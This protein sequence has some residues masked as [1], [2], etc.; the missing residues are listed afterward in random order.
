MHRKRG[1]GRQLL[2]GMLYVGSQLGCSNAWGLT[3]RSDKLAMRLYEAVGG[4]EASQVMFE[5]R[6]DSPDVPE[7]ENA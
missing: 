1:L 7:S 4:V 3:D 5:F 2:K 6:I